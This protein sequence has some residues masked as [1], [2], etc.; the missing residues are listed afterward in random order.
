[1]KTPPPRSEI[2]D[3]V[4]NYFRR[5][6]VQVEPRRPWRR[7]SCQDLAA[8]VSGHTIGSVSEVLDVLAACG[9]KRFNGKISH[10]SSVRF[11]RSLVMTLCSGG[12][13]DTEQDWTA[14]LRMSPGQCR[15]AGRWGIL[16]HASAIRLRDVIRARH[17]GYSLS[18][19]ACLLCLFRGQPE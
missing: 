19:L 1:M 17:P 2:V 11:A 16:E 5:L 10:Y 13:H 18:D 6:C 7:A 4:Y 3:V 8:Y 9:S 12:F 15:K 14:L